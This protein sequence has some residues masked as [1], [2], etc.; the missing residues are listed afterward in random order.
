LFGFAC[1]VCPHTLTE[2]KQLNI[3]C[4]GSDNGGVRDRSVRFDGGRV[5]G[6]RFFDWSLVGSLVRS[7]LRDRADDGEPVA[8][9]ATG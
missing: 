3:E 4:F 1:P 5:L 9:S 7:V 2:V 6:G 8:S